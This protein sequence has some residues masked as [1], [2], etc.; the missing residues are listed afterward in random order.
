MTHAKVLTT[1]SIVIVNLQ[2]N[3]MIFYLYSEELQEPTSE[4]YIT[5]PSIPPS[6]TSSLMINCGDSNL[7][8]FSYK[9]FLSKLFTEQTMTSELY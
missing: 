3:A 7:L 4:M 9:I 8:I 1:I 2:Y 5:D 6:T